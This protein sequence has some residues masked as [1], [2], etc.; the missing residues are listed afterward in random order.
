MSGIIIPSSPEDRAR[1]K[2][3]M[4]ELSNSFT[5]TEAERDFV[6]EAIAALS[7]E[8]EI[9]KKVLNKM[10]KI[11]HKQNLSE[12]VGDVTDVEELYETIMGQ[13]A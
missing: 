13:K 9:P 6:K 2:S 10:A 8:V 11:F 4:E 5:R 7:E 1:I 12:V 3:C